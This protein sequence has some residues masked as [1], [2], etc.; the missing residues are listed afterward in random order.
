MEKT[1]D[2][3]DN[4]PLCLKQNRN[5]HIFKDL[6]TRDES[7]SSTRMPSDKQTNFHQ[8]ESEPKPLCRFPYGKPENKGKKTYFSEKACSDSVDQGLSKCSTY[9]LPSQNNTSLGYTAKRK[10]WPPVMLGMNTVE[11]PPTLSDSTSF[12][13]ANQRPGF[14][15]NFDA[16]LSCTSVDCANLQPEVLSAET[17]QSPSIFMNE[18]NQFDLVEGIRQRSDNFKARVDSYNGDTTSNEKNSLHSTSCQHQCSFNDDD[19]KMV[20]GKSNPKW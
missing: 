12:S 14:G 16:C 5:N 9:N 3:E 15:F 17:H 18:Q 13:K 7:I 4:L 11:R 2:G 1:Q 19:Q 8:K 6:K 20:S 10:S